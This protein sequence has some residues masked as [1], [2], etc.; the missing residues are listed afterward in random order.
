MNCQKEEA[1]KE[2]TKETFLNKQKQEGKSLE[3]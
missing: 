1:Q 2:N 3:Y